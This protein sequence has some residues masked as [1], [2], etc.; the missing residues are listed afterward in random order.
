MSEPSVI[1]PVGVPAPEEIPAL[2]SEQESPPLWARLDAQKED[3]QWTELDDVKLEN[4]KRWLKVY[5]WVL[6]AVTVVFASVFI[7]SFVAWAFHH[8]T[9]WTWL[10]P[11]Q[12]DKIQSIL[13]SGGMGAIV[14]G[15]IRSQISKAQ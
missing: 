14:T 6:V 5:G 3:R 9:P 8:L 1:G 2:S 13:F 7:G 12:I 11:E 15:I 4:D 10:D